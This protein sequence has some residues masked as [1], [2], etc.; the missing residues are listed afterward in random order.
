MATARDLELLDDYLGNRMDAKSRAAF[1]QQMNADQELRGEMQ[2]QQQ[3]IAGIKKARVAELKSMLNNV[4]IPAGQTTGVAVGAKVALGVAIAGLIAS[5]IYLYVDN[6][7]QEI[8]V[9]RTDSVM[10]PQAEQEPVT[11]ETPAEEQSAEATHE[12]SPVVS[13]QESSAERKPVAP[14][15]PGKKAPTA[16]ATQKIEVYDPSTELDENNSAQVTEE[17]NH[18]EASVTPS[19]AVEIDS[20]NKKYNFHY[21]FKDGKLFLY[22]PFENNVYEIM[23]FFNEEKRT[24]FLYY[25]EKYYL[26]KDNNASLKPLN[27]IQDAELLNKLKEYRNK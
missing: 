11:K 20:K 13:S 7:S 5:G 16:D 21:Q 9:P 4:P 14:P 22:G 23:E 17:L 25:N 12:D 18:S 3:M 6:D 27:S 8:V 1:E 15:K 24:L 10:T 2:M 19:I 26:L